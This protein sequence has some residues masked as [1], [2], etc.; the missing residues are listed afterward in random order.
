MSSSYEVPLMLACIM[1][2]ILALMLLQCLCATCIHRK[3]HL[4]NL[5][6]LSHGGADVELQRPVRSTAAERLVPI[7]MSAMQA[8]LWSVE[9]EE[10]LRRL[11]RLERA[12]AAARRNALEDKDVPPAYDALFGQNLNDKDERPTYEALF[13]QLEKDEAQGKE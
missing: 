11:E 12:E 5:P 13:G 8:C 10:R 4:F 1:L 6:H 3:R 9:R 7:Q 2:L